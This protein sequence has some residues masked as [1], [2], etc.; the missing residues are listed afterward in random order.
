[1]PVRTLNKSSIRKRVCDEKYDWV[2]LETTGRHRP[3]Y[4]LICD[5][6]ALERKHCKCEG[7]ESIRK[8]TQISKSSRMLTIESVKPEEGGK[9]YCIHDR[10]QIHRIEDK[11]VVTR[12][13]K[14]TL[15]FYKNRYSKTN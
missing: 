5:G 1:M 4:V 7:L 10:E 2:K 13:G 15:R 9:Y 8:R 6:P 14:G 11:D 3:T 12:I